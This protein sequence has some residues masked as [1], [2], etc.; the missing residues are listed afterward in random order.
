[1][2]K[3]KHNR[4]WTPN[5]LKTARECA[6]EH[7]SARETAKVLG[8]TPGAVKYKCMIEGIAFNAIKQPKGV[9]V[10]L[11]RIRRKVGMHAV[12]RRRAA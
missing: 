9:Q 7:R 10:R 5:E 2:S 12:L 8:R 11:A 3:P 1:M 6:R 4:P